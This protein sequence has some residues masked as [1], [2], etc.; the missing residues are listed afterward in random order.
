MGFLGTCGNIGL[1]AVVLPSSM[2]LWIFLLQASKQHNR[3]LDLILLYLSQLVVFCSDP[4][5]SML[6]R[7]SE[8]FPY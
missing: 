5:L 4:F 3:P 7:Y 1:V 6:R 2:W 8:R